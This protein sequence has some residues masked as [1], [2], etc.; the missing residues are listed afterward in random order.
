[1][2]RFVAA[3]RAVLGSGMAIN[4][5]IL[6]LLLKLAA[7]AQGPKRLAPRLSGHAGNRR[8]TYPTVRSGHPQPHTIPRDSEA[9]LRWHNVTGQIKRL[10]ETKSLFRAVGIQ[11]DFLDI[12]AARG[13][14]IMGDLNA[15]IP[16]E[17]IG[18]Y[19]LVYDGGSM[20]HCFTVGQ[21]MRT[22]DALGKMGGTFCIFDPEDCFNRS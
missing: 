13:V 19:D 9:I 10:A 1:M 2:D 3:L 8:A 17:L 22:I 16:S 4:V 7:Q 21:V 18:R 6:E 11:T 15:A 12:H 14:E 20:E 5:Q